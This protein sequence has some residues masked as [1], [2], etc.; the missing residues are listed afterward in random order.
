MRSQSPSPSIVLNRVLNERIADLQPFE[1]PDEMQL[2]FAR[3]DAE[4]ALPALPSAVQESSL[5]QRM[6]TMA[7]SAIRIAH[8]ALGA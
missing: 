1:K 5:W 8:R 4:K 6:L 7:L 2:L 3:G